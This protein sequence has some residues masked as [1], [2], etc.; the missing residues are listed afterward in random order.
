MS[1]FGFRKLFSPNMDLL[2]SNVFHR[3][4][5]DVQI[6]T[7]KTQRPDSKGLPSYFGHLPG[8]HCCFKASYLFSF[9]FNIYNVNIASYYCNNNMTI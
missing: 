9:C 3:T 7:E 6:M 2:F 8:F 4:L 5:H 1:F